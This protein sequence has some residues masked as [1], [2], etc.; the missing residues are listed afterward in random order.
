MPQQRRFSR[1]LPVVV[2]FLCAFSAST[3]RGSDSAYENNLIERASATFGR[4]GQASGMEPGFEQ[5]IKCGTPLIYEIRMNW[6][7]LSAPTRAKIASVVSLERPVLAERYDTPDGRFRIHFTRYGS[8]SVNMTFGVGAGRVPNYVLRC[9]A[10]LDTVVTREITDMKYRYPISD[11]VPRPQE[12]PRYDI[13]MTNL[14]PLFYGIT[15]PDTL[16]IGQTSR[17]LTSW[18][19]ISSDYTQLPGYSARPFDA[20][21][22][23]I[24]HEFFHAIQWTYDAD[25]AEYRGGV[26]YPWF[27]EISSTWM[28]DMV[29]TRVNDYYAYLANFFQYPWI[30]LRVIGN[31]HDPFPEQLHPYASA[32]WG[33]FLSERYGEDIVREI[34]E[35][36]GNVPRF[37]TF[38]A[39]ES[40]L[41]KHGTSFAAGWAE[42]LVWNYYTGQRAAPWSYSEGAAFAPPPSYYGGQLPDTLI[43]RYGRYPLEDSSSRSLRAPFNADELAASYL[44]FTPP[45]GASR[46]FHLQ[47]NTT[48]FPNEMIVIAGGSDSAGKPHIEFTT[49]ASHTVTVPDWAV[50]GDI[51]V[52]VSPFKS[53]V[54]Q[55]VLDRNIAYRLVANDSLPERSVL[56]VCDTS[57]QP[58]GPSAI[59]KIYS[60]PLHLPAD[61]DSLFGVDVTIPLH[62][63]L[64]DVSMKIFTPDGR[65][66]SGKMRPIP[67]SRPARLRWNGRSSDGKLVASGIYLALVQ[68]DGKKEVVKI[69]VRNDR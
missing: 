17:Q 25:E 61:A 18:I 20:M 50:C 34:W 19:E 45:T 13:Y 32:I 57:S 33:R 54:S 12:D 28:E 37:N 1:L 36:C 42:F 35:E 9:A 11:R 4:V 46:D 21:A 39:F 60:N 8:D 69:A 65:L 30:S 51:L 52:I 26:F 27:H 24:A 41:S 66:V 59:L 10:L 7:N 31:S 15:Y 38:E 3:S 55:D 16:V 64:D 6:P 47:I 2:A 29:F 67:G 68:F 5:V 23:T 44:M 22:V 43:A 63:S 14:G 40:T 56:A 49:D 62:A 53:N 58:P 48:V